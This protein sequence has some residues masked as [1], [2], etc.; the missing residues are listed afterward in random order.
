MAFII[1]SSVSQT[2]P[3]EADTMTLLSEL[4]I[5]SLA[6]IIF[7]LLIML[8]WRTKGGNKG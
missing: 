6:L 1:S 7:G 5:A 2:D 3:I 4:G 8:L